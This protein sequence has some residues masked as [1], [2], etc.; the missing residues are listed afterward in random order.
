MTRAALVTGAGQNIGR[1]V[2]LA[3][4]ADGFDIVVNGQSNRA[5]CDETAEMVTGAGRQALVAMGDVG[6]AGACRRIADEGIA[7]FGRIDVLVAN[8]AIRPASVISNEPEEDAP[9]LVVKSSVPVNPS[10]V[11]TCNTSPVANT[12]EV[13]GSV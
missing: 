5:A 12:P 10:A 6:E 3:L 1:A 13:A 8:A 9:P 11:T 4:A 7:R 2:A